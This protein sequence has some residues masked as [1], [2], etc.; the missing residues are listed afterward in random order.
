MIELADRTREAFRKHHPGLLQPDEQVIRQFVV[1]QR[2]LD[3]LLEILRGNLDSPSCQHALI[4]GPRGRGKSTLLARVAAE[5]RTE[6]AFASRVVPVRFADESAGIFNATSFWLDA[7]F[8]VAREVESR[9][10][11]LARELRETRSDLIRR[12]RGDAL[13]ERALGAVLEGAERMNR[14]LVLMVENLHAL[15]GNANDDFGW[16]L[17]ATLQSEPQI[18]LLGTA[19]THFEALDDAGAPFFE[20]FRNVNLE[21]LS[22]E[23]CR[24]LWERVAG[25][26]L[27]GR[28]IRPIEI[29]TGGSPRLLVIAG[30]FA[31]H[32]SPRSLME[33]LAVLV[34]DHS[35]YF[36]SQI[37][38]LPVS[39][40]RVFLAVADLWRPSEAREIA[41]R[42]MMDIRSASVML[43]RL[44]N[45]GAIVKEGEGKKP[46]YSVAERLFSI[47]YQ[48]QREQNGAGVIHNLVRYMA[49]A[50]GSGE[51]HERLSGL[52]VEAETAPEVREGLAR[53]VA[54]QPGLL[55]V[56]RHGDEEL[57]NHLRSRA[58][59]IGEDALNQQLLGITA[60][61]VR[62]DFAEAVEFLDQM[63]RTDGGFGWAPQSYRY[64]MWL[65]A[66]AHCR[67]Y[68]R[69]TD[70]MLDSLQE[71]AS[72]FEQTEKPFLKKHV[73]L[74]LTTIANHQVRAG[75]PD[76]AL[77]TCNRVV[78]LFGNSP[79]PALQNSVASALNTSGAAHGAL[80]DS[81]AAQAAHE[82]L[83]ARFAASED[84]DLQGEIAVAMVNRGM[85]LAMADD[86]GRGAALLH[87]VV[88]RFGDTPDEKCVFSVGA[89]LV[90]MSLESQL[91]GKTQEAL[92][93]LC[94]AID[95]LGRLD[96]PQVQPL[97][98]S[99]M[100]RKG[101]LLVKKGDAEGGIKEY[102]RVVDRFAAAN[103]AELDVCVAEA[104]LN[105][106]FAHR[107]RDETALAV[108]RWDEVVQRFGDS[109]APG[110][111]RQVADALLA[112]A[113]QRRISGSSEEVL[114]LCDD[115]ARRCGRVPD[116]GRASL[117]WKVQCV[118]VRAYLKIGFSDAALEAFRAGYEV[119]A[120]KSDLMVSVMQRLVPELVG[121][122]A[123]PAELAQLLS[124]DPAKAASL[125]PLIAALR[126][127][128]GESLRVPA[129]V[130]EVAKDIGA[131][132]N[133]KT[134]IPPE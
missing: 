102:A 15:F 59:E 108:E 109:A 105:Q 52:V 131:L 99:A 73:G 111:Q 93:A 116:A 113:L 84:P 76:A 30:R 86:S 37:A 110:V 14:R 16:K 123:S 97:L 101:E 57:L 107:L 6:P 98:A 25:E 63:H 13:E 127:R 118:R 132:M 42:A 134:A 47:Y 46:L 90:W 29:L 54:E 18:I 74:A 64:A 28:N 27:D 7:S 5:L 39:E 51:G 12:W 82:N 35:E 69:Q 11:E 45:R 78:E 65:L 31:E 88:A 40:R 36:R 43:G 71:F 66:Q 119:F 115:I 38:A 60:A 75:S 103:G 26:S 21:P 85:F 17:R 53:A 120:P 56:F 50:Y 72:R 8:H 129:E 2:E 89:A 23:E 22:S 19:T 70:E 117:T 24:R 32:P 20:L 10:P 4:L 91:R 9:E 95:R 125:S 55:R 1:R 41:T 121:A 79:T 106:G 62:R 44:K 67:E 124:S 61:L 3:I 96:S 77:V 104:L 58:E 100:I 33:R 133:G 80:G 83:L 130:R 126:H 112:K 128:A 49:L 87:D 68:L 34:D 81:K 92:D 48:L 122:G 94:H 114:G